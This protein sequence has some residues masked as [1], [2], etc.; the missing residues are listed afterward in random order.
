M[1]VNIKKI[2]IRDVK[3]L[4]RWVN[5]EDSLANKIITKSKIN[6]KSHVKW[7]RKYLT[8]GNNNLIWIILFNNNRATN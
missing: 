1:N 6:V 8:T 5:T 7:V 2:D 4:Y 3:I